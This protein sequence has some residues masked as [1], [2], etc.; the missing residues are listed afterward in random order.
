MIRL[1]LNNESLTDEMESI[2]CPVVITCF[3]IDDP[4]SQSGKRSTVVCDIK[5]KMCFDI[6]L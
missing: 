2:L 6:L 1:V 4:G 5:L 3:G